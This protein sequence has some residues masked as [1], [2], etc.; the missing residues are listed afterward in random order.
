MSPWD[1]R[2]FPEPP[3][4]KAE[5]LSWHLKGVNERLYLYEI[6]TFGLV[7]PTVQL[8]GPVLNLTS[9]PL[10]ADRVLNV[11]LAL[12]M[13]LTKE[14]LMARMLRAMIVLA[15]IFIAQSASAGNWYV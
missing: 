2:P 1:R 13:S 6:R 5:D 9:R 14:P 3:I 4:E 7:S 10:A 8:F 11:T 15:G 12:E